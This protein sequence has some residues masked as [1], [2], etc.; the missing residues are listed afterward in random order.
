MSEELKAKIL[1][2]DD[3]EQFLDVFSKRLKSRGVLVETASN[4][5]EGVKKA[6][7]QAY[8][9]IIVD[10]AMPGID[11]IETLRQIKDKNPDA[12]IIILTGHATIEKGIEAMKA[13]AADFIEKPVDI[14]KVLQAIKESGQK[15][16]LVFEKTT[17]EEIKDL[18]DFKALLRDNVYDQK[19]KELLVPIDRYPRIPHQ[20]TVGEALVEIK[21]YIEK[22]YRHILVFDERFQLLSVLSLRDLLKEMLPDFLKTTPPSKYEGYSTVGDASLAALWQESFFKNCRKQAK[23]P[24]SEM[25]SPVKT[26]VDADD[27]VLKALFIM[28]RDDVHVLPVLRDGVVIGVIRLVD[29][30]SLVLCVCNLKEEV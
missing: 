13:G 28:L 8:D 27:P 5:L 7:E 16:A 10:L 20:F 6:G 19:V 18:F 14:N 22:G 9:A 23:K 12:Q 21:T 1:L 25:L 30:L 2:V 17:E 24:I 11:G 4:G 26:T 15:K 29:I 3:E